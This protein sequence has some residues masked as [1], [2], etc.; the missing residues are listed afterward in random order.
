MKETE[1]LA[2]SERLLPHISDVMIILSGVV[3]ETDNP[4]AI[5][6]YRHCLTNYAN[7]VIKFVL[8]PLKNDTKKIE[9]LMLKVL[10][11]IDSAPAQLYEEVFISFT[12]LLL[13][14]MRYCAQPLKDE[15]NI[16]KSVRKFID[17]MKDC[18]GKEMFLEKFQA[19][20]TE[21]LT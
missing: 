21:L 15:D 19:L 12:A 4:N 13:D 7:I 20:V 1:W 6:N 14:I 18:Q 8:S 11:I 3:V 2:R 16:V 5:N 17:N 10:K 9:K